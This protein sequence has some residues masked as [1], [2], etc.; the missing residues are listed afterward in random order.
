MKLLKEIKCNEEDLYDKGDLPAE[1]RREQVTWLWGDRTFHAEE[2]AV[3]AR[4]EST[5]GSQ[6][7]K[8][9]THVVGAE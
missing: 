8:L 4:W 3:A 9:G 1:F 6:S 7:R 5:L 2:R